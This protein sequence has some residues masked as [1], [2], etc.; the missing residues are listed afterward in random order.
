MSEA[1]SLLPLSFGIDDFKIVSET[2]VDEADLGKG[3]V[4]MVG[5]PRNRNLLS[6]LPPG[7]AVGD[8]WFE[9]N[10]KRYDEANDA[11]FAVFGHP[12]SEGRYMGLFYPLSSG[13]AAGVMR[14]ITHYGKYSYLTFKDGQN[15]DKGFWPVQDSPMIHRWE[16]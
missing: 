6:R 8:G 13:A 14:K 4:L 12:R 10:G 15:Q 5:L 16:H 1:A 9:L 11:L 7:L 3:D 2:P